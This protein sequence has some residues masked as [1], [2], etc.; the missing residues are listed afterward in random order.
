VQDFY[1]IPIAADTVEIDPLGPESGRFHVIRGPS[2]RSASLTEL[3]LA[4]RDYSVDARDDVG[5]RIA[6]NLSSEQVEN[7]KPEN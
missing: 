3:R 5:F 7:A 1:A 2:W 6:R 4:S